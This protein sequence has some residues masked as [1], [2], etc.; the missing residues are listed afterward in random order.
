M[1]ARGGVS[2]PTASSSS[3]RATARRELC[4]GSALSPHYPL[5]ATASFPISRRV[6]F[7]L[8][9]FS[10]APRRAA[11][12]TCRSERC[13]ASSRA[14]AS[15]PAAPPPTGERGAV[16]REGPPLHFGRGCEQAP[17]RRATSCRAST[18]GCTQ[19]RETPASLSR[20]ARGGCSGRRPRRARDRV[21]SQAL[22]LAAFES[23]E[24]LAS[25]RGSG[26]D[27]MV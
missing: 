4:V 24:L 8:T 16:L 10:T 6:L 3:A 18:A 26:G 23:E 15:P 9:A 17:S 21:V 22:D 27:E 2:A 14:R 13:D 1:A 20:T 5:D 12:Q 19:P 25:A 11:A 7:H